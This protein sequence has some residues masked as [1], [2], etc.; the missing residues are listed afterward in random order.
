M[1]GETASVTIAVISEDLPLHRQASL[2][3]IDESH[4][5]Y[6]PADFSQI[7][8]DVKEGYYE[9]I[10]QLMIQLQREYPEIRWQSREAELESNRTQV[11]RWTALLQA[12]TAVMI[13]LSIIGLMNGISAGIHARRRE[14]AVLRSIH[15]TPAQS[16]KLVLWQSG[17]LTLIALAMGACT[18][19]LLFMAIYNMGSNFTYI[20][21]YIPLSQYGLLCLILLLLSLLA[22][23]PMGLKLAKMRIME[24]FRSV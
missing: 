24:L 20:F 8:F 21:D 22:A 7:V 14:Y 11:Q 2:M 16:M 12:I 5:F 10:K 19:G 13:I 9:Q 4:P 1:E 15:L 3:L 17:I 23:L 6:E 18:V